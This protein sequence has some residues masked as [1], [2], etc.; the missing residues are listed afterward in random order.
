[1]EHKYDPFAFYFA[2]CAFGSEFVLP[3]FNSFFLPS[4][5]GSHHSSRMLE[6]RPRP[7]LLS[8][9]PRNIK[10]LPCFRLRCLVLGLHWKAGPL[11]FA[12]ATL[13]KTF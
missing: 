7:N 1:M 11:R 12:N 3:F 9:H 6:H 5:G 2:E 4:E 10:P 13:S 8:D